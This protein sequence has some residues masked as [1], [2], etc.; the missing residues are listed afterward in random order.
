[1]NIFANG[2]RAAVLSSRRWPCDRPPSAV[3]EAVPG[4]L[5]IYISVKLIMLS[6]KLIHIAHARVMEFAAIQ[7]SPL[8]IG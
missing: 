6:G 7:F 3:I 1:M 4:D 2:S 8:C 5:K